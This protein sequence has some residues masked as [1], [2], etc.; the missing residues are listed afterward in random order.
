[1]PRP[2]YRRLWGRRAAAETNGADPRPTLLAGVE[3]HA[4]DINGTDPRPALQ[5]STEAP[6]GEV[7]GADSWL[8]ICSCCA[9]EPAFSDDWQSANLYI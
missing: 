3:A 6:A 8:L 5:A 9:L 1:M 2:G 7:N 4:G